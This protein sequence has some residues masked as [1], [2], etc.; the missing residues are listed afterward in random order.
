MLKINQ[1][2]LHSCEICFT[3]H[4]LE[5]IP[6]LLNA[7]ANLNALDKDGKTALAYAEAAM[8]SSITLIT[9]RFNAYKLSHEEW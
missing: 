3:H 7:G 6:L 1:A 9:R 2:Q 8:A 5:V 4:N